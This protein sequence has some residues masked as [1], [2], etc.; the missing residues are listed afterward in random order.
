MAI[1]VIVLGVAVS[2]PFHI[3]VRERP[4]ASSQ[5]LRWYKWLLKPQFYLVHSYTLY[6]HY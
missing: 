4:D 6:V 2:T 3:F 5:T 1:V